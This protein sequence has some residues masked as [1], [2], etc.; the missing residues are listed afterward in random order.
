[1]AMAVIGYKLHRQT[2]T[3]RGN[4]HSLSQFQL[5]K[6]LGVWW[7]INKS[8]TLEKEQEMDSTAYLDAISHYVQRFVVRIF[9]GLFLGFFFVFFLLLFLGS[10]DDSA[11]CRSC[12][13]CYPSRNSGTV[14]LL[15]IS[16]PPLLSQY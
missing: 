12:C 15:L 1:M 7:C 3:E 9:L 8:K 13:L 14:L 10:K 5:F 16:S 2:W 11:K 4:N 6:I